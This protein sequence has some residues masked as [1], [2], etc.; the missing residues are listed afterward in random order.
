MKTKPLDVAVVIRG[1]SFWGRFQ[2]HI[3]WSHP[4][5]ISISDSLFRQW[6]VT[7]SAIEIQQGRA[8][9]N[10]NYFTNNIGN[11]I[12]ISENVDKVIVTNNQFN[13]NTLNIVTKPTVLVANNLP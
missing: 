10:N 9:I 3:L 4:G 5:L 12:T 11:A 13:N 7:S 2:Q 6:N 8:M 1:A